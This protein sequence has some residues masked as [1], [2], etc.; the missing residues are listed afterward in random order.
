MNFKR[1]MKVRFSK[2]SVYELPSSIGKKHCLTIEEDL[3][4]EVESLTPYGYVIVNFT[5]VKGFKLT[6]TVEPSFLVELQ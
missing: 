1:G 3:V 2:S 5:I 6:F 4:G